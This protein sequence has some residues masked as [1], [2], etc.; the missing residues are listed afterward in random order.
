[1]SHDMLLGILIGVTIGAAIQCAFTIAFD[2]WLRRLWDL[3]K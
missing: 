2:R 3:R 1:M